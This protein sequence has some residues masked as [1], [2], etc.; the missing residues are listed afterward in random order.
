MSLL[1]TEIE[2]L[3][4][5]PEGEKWRYEVLQTAYAGN[6]QNIGLVTTL[7]LQGQIRWGWERARIGSAFSWK[8]I[9]TGFLLSPL[10]VLEACR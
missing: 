6:A 5:C 7:M 3:C 9:P 10:T 4:P 8:L 2:L 1:P